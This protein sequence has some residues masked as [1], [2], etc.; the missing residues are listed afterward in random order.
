MIE[1]LLQSMGVNPEM[2]TTAREDLRKVAAAVDTVPDLSRKIDNM[3]IKVNKLLEVLENGRVDRSTSN[4][5][6]GTS[7]HDRSNDTGT[8]SDFDGTGH[9]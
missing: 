4:R 5:I 1:S 2:I 6:Y 9:A 7:D 8:A 3:E